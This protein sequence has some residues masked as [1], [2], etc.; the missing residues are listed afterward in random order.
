MLTRLWA[1]S[2]SDLEASL[3]QLGLPAS[4]LVFIV[5]WRARV[6]SFVYSLGILQCPSWGGIWR[7]RSLFLSIER[8]RTLRPGEGQRQEEN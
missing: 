6:P 4:A 1:E 2:G 8:L 3:S 7:S 5:D